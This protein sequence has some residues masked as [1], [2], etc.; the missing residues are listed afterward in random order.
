MKYS[1]VLILLTLTFIGASKIKK[2]SKSEDV[3]CEL[4]NWT[5]W[6]SCKPCGIESRSRNRTILVS[7]KN[8]GQQCGP[9]FEITDCAENPC[10]DTG[11][12]SVSSATAVTRVATDNFLCE[13]IVAIHSCDFLREQCNVDPANDSC[14]HFQKCC[15]YCS[16]L[17]VAVGCEFMRDACNSKP[18]N[19]QDCQD[20]SKCC[21]EC[22]GDYE[23]IEISTTSQG[24]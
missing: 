9:T 5:Q 13:E 21:G 17:L 24:N 1:G 7:P 20:C 3:D 11:T 4:S 16:E 10:T 2:A 15:G 14:E 18:S 22:V 8:E 12:S 23:Y 6:S 19:S